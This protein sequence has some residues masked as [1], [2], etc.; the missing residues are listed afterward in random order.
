MLN[1]SDSETRIASQLLRAA[2]AHFDA[3]RQSALATL[4]IYLH[5]PTA[6][7]NHPN[8]VS[9]I[10]TATKDLAE[11]EQ[12]LD[13]LERNF[14]VSQDNTLGAAEGDTDADT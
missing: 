5:K 10:V 8:L 11:A 3:Q 14:L 7:G 2:L 12:A 1:D 9:E 13:T 4:D 6:I